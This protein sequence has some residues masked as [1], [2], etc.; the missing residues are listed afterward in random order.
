M[1][2]QVY[3]IS[4]FPEAPHRK[5]RKKR[6]KGRK[7]RIAKTKVFDVEFISWKWSWK[8]IFEMWFL[9]HLKRKTISFRQQTNP[10]METYSIWIAFPR[11]NFCEFNEKKIR[12]TFI[13]TRYSNNRH[14][15]HRRSIAIFIHCWNKKN[16]RY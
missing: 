2:L 4:S 14:L 3:S 5:I 16:K 12:R 15:E 9:N 1:F 13:C 11:M 6:T 8:Q 10:S 7:L